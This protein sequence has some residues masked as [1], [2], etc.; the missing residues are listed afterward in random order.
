M[1]AGA[2]AIALIAVFGLLYLVVV[3]G[4]SHFWP[5]EVYQFEIAGET[6]IA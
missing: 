4:M 5:D 2:I 3:R 1:N 6:I